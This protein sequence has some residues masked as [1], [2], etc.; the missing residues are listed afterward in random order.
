M[1]WFESGPSVRY[2]GVPTKNWAGNQRCVPV[3]VHLPTSTT[4]VAA[5]VRTAAEAGERVKVIGGA[6][7]FTDIAMTD[8]H[9]LSLDA[10]NR[11]LE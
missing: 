1:A 8:G 11:V 2:V 7:S 9:L 5:I 6:H 10:M 4:A 3:G